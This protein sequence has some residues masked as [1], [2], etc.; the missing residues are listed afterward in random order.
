MDQP[1]A[2]E[3]R[4]YA[5]RRP[6]SSLSMFDLERSS[7]TSQ[8]A[9]WANPEASRQRYLDQVR[10]ALPRLPPLDR[11]VL[12]LYVI[13]G[14]TQRQIQ[15]LVGLTQQ[16][17]CRRLD[18]ATRRMEF[19]IGHPRIADRMGELLPAYLTD[20]REV[21]V[22]TRFA[23]LAHQTRIAKDIRLSQQW[24]NTLYLRGLTRLLAHPSL[25][26]QYLA[27]W[28]IQLAQQRCL[29]ESKRRPRR[30]SR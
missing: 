18:A 23:T 22:L 28:Y 29:Y 4:Y 27:V 5:R 19:L 13:Q 14:L 10:D 9:V 21:E 30:R 16:G 12:H 8:G 20:P 15:P 2:T 17:V 26:A 1:D 24:T 7:L 25:T 3:T 11:D 6:A